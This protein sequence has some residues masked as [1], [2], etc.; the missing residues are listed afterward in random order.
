MMFNVIIA[1]HCLVGE[2]IEH[3]LLD[4]TGVNQQYD[5]RHPLS[6]GREIPL[7]KISPTCH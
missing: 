3:N 4:V 7:I 2:V 6:S 1:G 5:L